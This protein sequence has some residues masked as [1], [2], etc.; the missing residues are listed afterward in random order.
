M[1]SRLQRLVPLRLVAR[2]GASREN[3]PATRSDAELTAAVVRGEKELGAEVC[4]RLLHVVDATLFRMLGRRESDHD[5]LVQSALEQ[6]VSTIYA[7]KFS[8]RCSLTTWASAIACHV[9]LHAIRRRKSERKLFDDAEPESRSLAAG[10]TERQIHARQELER[11]REHLSQM[12]T[13]LAETLV[14]H[15]IMGFGLQE[16]ALLVKASAAATQSR[17]ARG[18][19]E[20]AERLQRDAA[21]EKGGISQ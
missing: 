12:S 8:G 1:P 6:I 18:R 19:K 2:D 5:D 4:T 16:T 13:K 21:R 7:G 17:L 14:L 20:L 10:D 3:E 9:A 11:V 15:D